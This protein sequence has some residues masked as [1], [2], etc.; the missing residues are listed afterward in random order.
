VTGAR[1]LA[2]FA[3]AAACAGCSGGGGGGDAG[4]TAA[5]SGNFA[6]RST[7]PGNCPTLEPGAGATEGDTELRFSVGSAALHQTVG[8]SIDLGAAPAPGGYAPT[9]VREWTALSLRGVENG[10]CVYR[11]GSDAVPPGTF[12]LTLDAVDLDA[13]TVHG[14]LELIQYVLAVS[15]ADC[16]R[17]DTETIDLTF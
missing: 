4:C 2:G 14:S 5:F 16:G 17:G 9:T 7:D 10:T 1:W 3:A 6:E 12:A 11:A 8:I 13:G 15:T